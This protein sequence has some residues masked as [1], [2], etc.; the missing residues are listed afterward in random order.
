MKRIGR[1][2]AE[3]ALDEQTIESFQHTLPLLVS[4]HILL[5]LAKS[6]Q[7]LVAHLGGGHVSRLERLQSGF[8]LFIAELQFLCHRRSGRWEQAQAHRYS[9]SHYSTDSRKQK[10]S[11]MYKV[12]SLWVCKNL[13]M[14]S[15]RTTEPSKEKAQESYC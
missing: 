3:Q 13:I 11:V 7:Y 14:G 9:P 1:L 2:V 4:R 12:N 10:P 5:A 15:K 6:H 8:Y